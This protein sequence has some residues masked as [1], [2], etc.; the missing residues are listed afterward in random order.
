MPPQTCT[1]QRYEEDELWYELAGCILG[2]RVSY[3]QAVAALRYL[4]STGLLHFDPDRAKL[5]EFEKRLVEA[6]SQPIFP[7]NRKARLQRY[8]FPVLRANHLR[9]TAAAIYLSGG[10]LH[11]ILACGSNP[12]D[13]R[14]RIVS[15]AIGVGPK[16]AS[17]FLRN[18]GYADDL[19]I[20][21]RHVLQ[22]MTWLGLM[23]GSINEVHTLRGYEHTESAFRMHAKQMGFSVAD[24]DLAVWIVVRILRREFVL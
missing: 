6:L 5:M 19:A 12:M 8:R 16:Q 3:E 10:S 24:L 15:V 9:R 14:V 2:S 4:R 11:Q 7:S 21:D 20:L 1:W 23:P 22:Y 18:I 17:L 13:A